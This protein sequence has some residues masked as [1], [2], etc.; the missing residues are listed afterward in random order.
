MKTSIAASVLAAVVGLSM[1]RPDTAAAQLS[2]GGRTLGGGAGFKVDCT[3][4]FGEDTI[5]EHTV[6]IKEMCATI[7][8]DNNCAIT[9]RLKDAG[10]GNLVTANVNYN[11]TLTR[12]ARGVKSVTLQRTAPG[13]LATVNW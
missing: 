10:G 3:G 7:Q 12:C 2:A 4:V 8:A 5:F 1:A 6:P 11:N 13:G 9:M